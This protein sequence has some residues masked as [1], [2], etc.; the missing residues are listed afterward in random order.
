MFV[1]IAIKAIAIQLIYAAV[2]LG[3]D[4]LAHRKS[5]KKQA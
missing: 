4:W 2:V 5:A 1:D 3:V